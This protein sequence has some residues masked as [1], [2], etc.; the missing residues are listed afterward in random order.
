[1]S[2]DHLALQRNSPIRLPLYYSSTL[3]LHPHCDW[4]KET[5]RTRVNLR[6]GYIRGIFFLL[7]LV[8]HL[9]LGTHA[10]L[11]L[12]V[13]GYSVT[14]YLLLLSTRTK[15][16][17][18]E[19]FKFARNLKQRSTDDNPVKSLYYDNR[20]H[21]TKTQTGIVRE[22]DIFLVAKINS[23]Y[24]GYVTPSSGTAYDE[25]TFFVMLTCMY[26]VIVTVFRCCF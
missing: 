12:Y 5:R 8:D 6:A 9:I 26:V 4:Q 1:M 13:L 24:V 7:N 21:E 10:Q 2:E 18:H 20:M 25:I 15:W 23:Q 11:K 19:N 17:K 16:R 22:E 14:Q 3:S